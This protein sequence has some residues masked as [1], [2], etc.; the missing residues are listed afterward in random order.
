M[1]GARGKGLET[2]VIASQRG[3]IVLE[4]I[5]N[6]HKF[7]RGG[8]SVALRGPVDFVGSIVADGGA[9]WF[10]AKQCANPN[11]FA[12]ARDHLPEHQRFLLIRHGN[13]GAVAGCLCEA[14]H[15][16]LGKYFWL[17]WQ[18]L[19]DSRISYPWNELIDLGP[20]KYL[21]DF[22]ILID[23]HRKVMAPVGFLYQQRKGA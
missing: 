22:K 7:I 23:A 1:I 6:T 11:R 21:I 19:T 9:I 14:T 13:C 15:A 5:F 10:D 16:T 17:P 3:V 12:A 8:K 20:T 18:L 4:K 2:T